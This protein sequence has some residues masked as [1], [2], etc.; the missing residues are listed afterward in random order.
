MSHERSDYCNS[1]VHAVVDAVNEVRRVGWQA[2]KVGLVFLEDSLDF[3]LQSWDILDFR[4]VLVRTVSAD[5]TSRIWVHARELAVRL[6]RR[7]VE[8][9][10]VRAAQVL[11]IIV[12]DH[13][14]GSAWCERDG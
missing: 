2:D 5:L 11:H 8:V 1:A 12:V 4:N 13:R 10:L 14:Y 7:V 3:V 9:D 6:Q